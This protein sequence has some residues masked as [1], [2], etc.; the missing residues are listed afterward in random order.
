MNETL[1]SILH[2]V[3]LLM[4][5]PEA[6]SAITAVLVAAGHRIYVFIQHNKEKNKALKYLA[7]NISE[8]EI[9]NRLKLTL[10]QV[11]AIAKRAEDKD[12]K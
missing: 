3:N 6:V 2:V 12:K 11:K 8:D 7:D 10:V 5:H 1:K 4:A 9:T